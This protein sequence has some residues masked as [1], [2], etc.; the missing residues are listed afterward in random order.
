MKCVFYGQHKVAF[1]V[2]FCLI[3]FTAF[4]LV[5]CC[6]IPEE[7]L[8]AHPRR[9]PLSNL[10]HIPNHVGKWKSKQNTHIYAGN[11]ECGE[12]KQD[13][14]TQSQYLQTQS[15]QE[16]ILLACVLTT[17]S[18]AAVSFTVR[19]HHCLNFPEDLPWA[20][21]FSTIVSCGWLPPSHRGRETPKRLKCSYSVTSNSQ[22]SSVPNSK[23]FPKIAS[24][25]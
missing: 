2:L 4:G 17:Q 25:L 23:P 21:P 18:G 1:Y 13:F 22:S 20:C 5:R 15:S 24:D 14:C 12:A 7:P 19:A 3:S 9:W 6:P 10:R 11:R 8:S 16:T